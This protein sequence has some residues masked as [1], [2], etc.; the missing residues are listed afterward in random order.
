[1]L[2]PGPCSPNSPVPAHQTLFAFKDNGK[3]TWWDILD[4]G[5]QTQINSEQEL[6]GMRTEA[7]YRVCGR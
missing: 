6:R 4:T 3:S 7:D 1:M 2:T 5:R